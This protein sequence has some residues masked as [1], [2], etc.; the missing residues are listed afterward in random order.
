MSKLDNKKVG[1]CAIY[2]L[3]NIFIVILHKFN[4]QF[5]NFR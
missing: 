3:V 1:I 2:T 4:P 5:Y